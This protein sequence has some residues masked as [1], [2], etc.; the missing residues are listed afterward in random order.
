[1]G[2]KPPAG[3]QNVILPIFITV[4]DLQIALHPVQLDRDGVKIVVVPLLHDLNVDGMP[5]QHRPCTVKIV[6]EN[7]AVPI[8]IDVG[9]T[10]EVE[11]DPLLRTDVEQIAP[12]RRKHIHLRRTETDKGIAAAIQPVDTED[13]LPLRRRRTDAFHI[14]ASREELLRLIGQLSIEHGVEQTFLRHQCRILIR[15]RRKA[16]RIAIVGVV[17]GDAAATTTVVAMHLVDARILHRSYKG[18]GTWK[19]PR[20]LLGQPRQIDHVRITHLARIAAVVLRTLRRTVKCRKERRRQMRR[21]GKH[22]AA[23]SLICGCEC[24]QTPK[25]DHGE[26]RL[27]LRIRL[28]AARKVRIADHRAKPCTAHGGIVGERP[29]PRIVVPPVARLHLL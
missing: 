1:M 5:V 26:R 28:P 24:G 29:D 16:V 15:I 2:I 20:R 9:I 3:A 13:R 8:C 7:A 21:T 17:G 22:I 6:F 11:N 18:G 19:L 12:N 4:G 23:V 25:V 27:L 14:A 10:A